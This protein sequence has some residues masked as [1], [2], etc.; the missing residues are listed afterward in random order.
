MFRRQQPQL[1][2]HQ[3]PH[4]HRK[5]GQSQ[6]RDGQSHAP[7]VGRQQGQFGQPGLQGIGQGRFADGAA[8]NAHGGN[9]HLDGGQ[10]AGG[11]LMQGEGRLGAAPA[12]IGHVLQTGFAGGDHGNFR[13]GEKAVNQ[14]QQQ[15]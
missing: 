5:I 9:A 1:L 12:F 14:D 7:G 4:H 6:H 11:L 15:Q 3:F 8:Q 13:H 2:G 10:K